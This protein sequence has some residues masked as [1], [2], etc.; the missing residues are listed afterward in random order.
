MGREKWRLVARVG[1]MDLEDTWALPQP[2][3]GDGNEGKELD[4]DSLVNVE[5]SE[6]MVEV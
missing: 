5:A 3:D 2:L 1:E 4:K 6:V